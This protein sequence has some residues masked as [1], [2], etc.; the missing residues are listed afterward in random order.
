M[1]L[2][3]SNDGP[4]FPSEFVDSLLSG[5][6]IFLTGTGVSAPQ[7]PEFQSL[8]ERTYET[9]AVEKT[10]SEQTAFDAG[11]FE[12]VLGSLRRRL[13]DP[14]AM[15]RTVSEILTVPNDPNPDISSE[16]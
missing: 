6:T 7:M 1:A 14:N 3:F 16:R 10:D 5:E 13:S 4:E 2:R 8:V 9:L 12:E 15:T 11:R